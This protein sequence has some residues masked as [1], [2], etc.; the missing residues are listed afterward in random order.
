MAYLHWFI[1]KA[2]MPHIYKPAKPK[3]QSQPYK[4]E[5]KRAECHSIYDTTQ[6]R[7]LRDVK[8]MNQPCCEMCAK[9][10]IVK[11]AD[12]IHHIIPFTSVTD[13]VERQALAFDYNN[14]MSLCTD[15]HR[16]VHGKHYIDEF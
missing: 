16:K 13:I 2:D 10:G 12:E 8:F 7:R 9:N 1:I 4:K 15:C 11:P 3:R 14:L 5:G 6:W